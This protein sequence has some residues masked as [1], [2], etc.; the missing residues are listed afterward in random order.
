MTSG[1]DQRR[2]ARLGLLDRSDPEG[3]EIATSGGGLVSCG[4]SPGV[5]QEVPVP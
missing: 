5:P 1:E 3:E 2:F 4:G